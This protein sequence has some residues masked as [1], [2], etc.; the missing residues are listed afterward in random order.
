MKNL[1]GVKCKVAS[2]FFNQ[3]LRYN[4][5]VCRYGLH[6]NVLLTD[7]ISITRSKSVSFVTLSR[8]KTSFHAEGQVHALPVLRKL[9]LHYNVLSGLTDVC[10]YV[11]ETI[12]V[13]WSKTCSSSLFHSFFNQHQY[14]C[15][16]KLKIL[17]WNIGMAYKAEATRLGCLVHILL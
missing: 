7:D 13:H 5:H 2:S 9:G 16:S 12:M 14:W 11:N 6:Y 10:M 1:L 15:T 17:M 8:R 3:F 4:V